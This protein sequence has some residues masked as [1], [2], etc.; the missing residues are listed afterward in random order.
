M[1]GRRSILC[2]TAGWAGILAAAFAGLRAPPARAAN[3]PA[4]PPGYRTEDY[5]SPTPHTL[6]G[7]RV[8]STEQ[9]HALWQ[10]HSA[11][12]VD[13]LPRP[14]HPAGLPPGT[15]W[16]PKPRQDIPGSIWLPDVGYGELAPVMEAFF[17]HGLEAAAGGRRERLLVFYCLPG[18]WHSWNAAKRALA[19][20]WP[21]VGWYPAGTDGWA[22]AGYPLE[23][24]TPIPRP[25]LTGDPS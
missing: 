11:T 8:L 3:A 19:L 24:R 16:H 4:E 7:A 12:F 6:T 2:G 22:E 10:A 5:R 20:G 1:S 18:C 15:I 25:D 23:E 21:N 17:R 9:A 13:T 14:P